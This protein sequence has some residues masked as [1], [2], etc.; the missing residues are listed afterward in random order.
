MLLDFLSVLDPTTILLIISSGL[1]V[2]ISLGLTGGGG[3]ILAV[4]LLIYVIGIK[5][6]H[7][8]IG[9]SALVVGII[10]AISMVGHK[11]HGHLRLKEGLIFAVPGIGGTIMGTQ[12]GLLTPANHLLLI[13][14]AFMMVMGYLTFTKKPNVS[15]T[16]NHVHDTILLQKNRVA[17][18]GFLV[19]IAAGYFGIG[20]GF[21]IVPALMHSVGLD[22]ID[23][24]GTSLLP[25]SVF[26]L[27]TATQYF[28]EGKINWLIAILFIIGGIGGGLV[29]TKFAMRIPRP[30]LLKVFGVLLFVVAIYMAVRTFTS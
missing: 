14:A 7:A 15:V 19:G 20:G 8:A 12:L 28:L 9:T 10:A 6:P 13:F 1:A 25:V 11:V 27:S 23:A 4:P 21:L 17:L 26:G 30:L 18:T 29:G 16:N 22:I 24:I 5:D 2:G 3:S